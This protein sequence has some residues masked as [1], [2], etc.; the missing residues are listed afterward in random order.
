[1]GFNLDRRQFLMGST[2]LLA[3]GA[4]SPAFAQETRMRLAWWGGQARAD[5]TDAATALFAK[6]HPGLTFDT[7]WNA[8]ND[9]W[10]KLGTEVAGGNA[11]DVYQMDD[12]YLVEYAVRGAIA[13]LDD[14]IGKELDLSDFDADQIEGGR[15]DG[16]LYAISL[17]AN[18]VAMMVNKKAFADAGMEEPTRDWSYDDY[19]ERADAFNA[20]SNGMKLLA[21]GSGAEPAL[22]NWLRQR[23]KALIPTA[24][25]AG[26]RTTSPSGSACGWTCATPGCASAPRT[27]RSTPRR[28]STRR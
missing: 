7:W 13:P 8:F 3:A 18:S 15:V 21:D 16:K 1:M 27:R 20:K 28:P 10:P 22:E 2:A 17:G 5:R 26:T 12:R 24:R 11:A 19:K 25:S 23:G 9:Y 4:V 6:A 14:Y